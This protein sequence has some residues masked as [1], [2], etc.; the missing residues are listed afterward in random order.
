MLTLEATPCCRGAPVSA[1]AYLAFP[2]PCHTCAARCPCK[3]HTCYSLSTF[4]Q[5][6]SSCLTNTSRNLMLVLALPWNSL[7]LGLYSLP[8]MV[9]MVLEC[10][11]KLPS[12]DLVKE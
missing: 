9:Y 5:P 12:A 2:R 8:H 6:M 3:F 7:Y 11:S 10:L 4:T 1:E